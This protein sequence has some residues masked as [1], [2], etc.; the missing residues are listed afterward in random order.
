[1][2]FNFVKVTRKSAYSVLE[3]IIWVSGQWQRQCSKGA[4]PFRGQNILEPGHPDALFS[5]KFSRVL[6]TSVIDFV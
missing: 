6:L 1:M 2:N 4:R 3:I 5:S